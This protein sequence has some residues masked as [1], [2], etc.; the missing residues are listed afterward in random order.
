MTMSSQTAAREGFSLIEVLVAITLLSVVMLSLGAGATLALSQMTKARQ[1]ISY[2]ADVQQVTDSL[3]AVGYNNVAA[4]SATVRGRSITW[5]VS[6]PNANSQKINVIV[7]RRG[8]ANTATVYTDT[9]AL[10]L[11]RTRVQ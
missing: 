7:P 9:V 2:S 4:G 3:L 5:T 1:D 10:Y 11:A 6:T 8:Q